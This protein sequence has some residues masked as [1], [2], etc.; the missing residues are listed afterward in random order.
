MTSLNSGSWTLTPTCQRRQRAKS[1]P[2]IHVLSE[3]GHFGPK[4]PI[5]L[6]TCILDQNTRFHWDRSKIN[7][8]KK[9]S[10]WNTRS[11]WERSA[12]IGRPKNPPVQIHVLTKN[13][14]FGAKYTFSLKSCILDQNT[15]FQSERR[16]ALFTPSDTL[17]F[18]SCILVQNTRFQWERVVWSKI[19]VFA[20]NVYLDGRI[21]WT[22]DGCG[23]FSVRTCILDQNTLSH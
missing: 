14:Y 9:S 7:P 10:R 17:L 20:E 22:A 15:R 1:A 11:Q 16:H 5:S 12:A 23:P 6:R 21:F 18:R 19:H 2:K 3:I 4:Y 13:V 8:W